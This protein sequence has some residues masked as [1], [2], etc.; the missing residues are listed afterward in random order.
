MPQQAFK[1]WP[2]SLA[3]NELKAACNN[4]PCAAGKESTSFLP[5]SVCFLA[6]YSRARSYILP[7]YSIDTA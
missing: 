7:T 3:L 1:P 5:S 4:K 6:T 2:R